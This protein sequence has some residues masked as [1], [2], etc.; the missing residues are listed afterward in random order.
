MGQGQ[1]IGPVDGLGRWWA[2]R[3]ILETSP[4]DQ[5]PRFT[6]SHLQSF[7]PSSLAWARAAYEVPGNLSTTSR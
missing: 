1:A 2:G 4:I 3:L 7:I 6:L 5:T